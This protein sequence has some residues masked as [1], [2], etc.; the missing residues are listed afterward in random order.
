MLL[1]RRIKGEEIESLEAQLTI[2]TDSYKNASQNSLMLGDS[3]KEGVIAESAN[4]EIRKQNLEISNEIAPVTTKIT[5]GYQNQKL[6][7]DSAAY[8]FTDL[9]NN[10]DQAA[11]SAIFAAGSITSTSDA[12]GAAKQ[13]AQQAAVAFIQAEIQKAVSSFISS[14]IAS[15]GALGFLV[16]PLALAG[17]AAF[18]SLMG[19]AVQRI[20]FTEAGYSGVVDKPTMFVTGK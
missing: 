10:M 12:M 1:L 17:G 3:I 6:A 15:A 8:S 2:I 14:Q 5:E 11:A 7:T 4:L 18:G 9:K 19:S 16:A 20:Q 13:A